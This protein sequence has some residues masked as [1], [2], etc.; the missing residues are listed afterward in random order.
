MRVRVLDGDRSC[1]QGI[2]IL[3]P[4]PMLP[5]HR[6]RTV[7]VEEG[8]R[9]VAT[10]SVLTVPYL[11]SAWLDRDHR[12]AGVVR[13]LVRGA[14]DVA[15]ADGTAWGFSAAADE[16]VARVLTRLG[17]TLLPV[18]M[19]MVPFYSGGEAPCR[20]GGG[21]LRTLQSEEGFTCRQP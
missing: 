2:P 4:A 19:F 10:M 16:N 5:P 17:G 6:V 7:V 18:Q 14:W 15:S 9:V 12:N 21:R 20:I 11:E 8:E 3:D 13:A 1:L